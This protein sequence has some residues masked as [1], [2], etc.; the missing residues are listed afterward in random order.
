MSMSLF[1]KK[2][3]L[4][5]I[6]LKNNIK[7][8]NKVVNSVFFFLN[9]KYVYNLSL[10]VSKILVDVYG[11]NKKF[12]V[13]KFVAFFGFSYNYKLFFILEKERTRFFTNV[14]IVFRNLCVGYSLQKYIVRN[15][16]RQYILRLYSGY[17]HKLCL[18]VRG[19]R[20]KTNAGT[21]K[22]KY[23]LLVEDTDSGRKRK[24]KRSR[25]KG[26]EVQKD[27]FNRNKAK[28]RNKRKSSRKTKK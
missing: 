26:K 11:L 13:L 28:S 5:A 14:Q 15:M 22:R 2:K 24:R 7:K 12:H 19:Q 21:Q 4:S 16:Y 18:P 3:K 8:Y 27:Y 17:R 6:I 9:K 10:K 1:L 25:S 20:T 23:L